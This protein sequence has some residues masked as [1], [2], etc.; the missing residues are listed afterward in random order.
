MELI[1]KSHLVVEINKRLQANGAFDTTFDTAWSEDIG[2]CNAY[3]SILS[4]IDT[5]E[6]KG[7]DLD[8]EIQNH[9][10]ECLNVKFPTTDIDL[11][12]KDVAYT[13]K[14]FFEFGLN[15]N[16]NAVIEKACNWLNKELY[17]RFN[18][19]EYFV[20]LSKEIILKEFIKNFKNYMLC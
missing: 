10:K 7:V 12:K 14:K 17:T 20:A 18:D 19:N 16:N 15:M 9:I 2:M 1:N 6:V 8:K 13:A 3:K 4:F 5:L 11:I